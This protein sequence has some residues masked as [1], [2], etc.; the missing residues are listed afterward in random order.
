MSLNRP[1]RLERAFARAS[2]VRSPSDPALSDPSVRR[3][4]RILDA[5]RDGLDAEPC[6]RSLRRRIEGWLLP[7]APRGAVRWMRALFDSGR[8]AAPA[9]RGFAR[10]PRTLRYVGAGATVDL[11]VQMSP[12]RGTVLLVAVSP[13]FPGATVEVRTLARGAPRRAVLDGEGTVEV[14]LPGRTR[15]V[16]VTIRL[17][18]ADP[19][20]TPT[21]HLY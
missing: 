8:D 11:Q 9:L 14:P 13:P 19:V 3:A 5:R 4:R 2:R 21:L 17:L 20:R 12:T 1:A 16:T 15:E 7:R 10:T 18:A 6:P